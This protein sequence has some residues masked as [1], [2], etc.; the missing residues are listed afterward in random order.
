M[1]TLHA[2]AALLLAALAACSS[3]APGPGGRTG[4]G[5]ARPTLE[6]EQARLAD[7]FRGTPVVFAMQGDGSLRVTVPLRY[8]FDHGRYAVKPPL[9]AVLDRVARSQRHESTRFAVAAP[10]DPNTR[11]VRLASDRAASTRDYL[12]ARG[13]EPTRFSITPLGEGDDVVLV[14][15]DA[16][17]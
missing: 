12:V 17:H 13:I 16:V 2:L 14:V 5:G 9:A 1:R 4:P 6:A 8:S 10:P 15:G 7:L 3:I 11:G